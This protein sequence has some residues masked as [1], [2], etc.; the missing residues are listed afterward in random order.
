MPERSS[1]RKARR[2]SLTSSLGEREVLSLRTE[3][4]LCISD[5]DFFEISEK[6]ENSIGRRIKDTETGQ[7]EIL[8][9]IG[10]PVLEDRFSVRTNVKYRRLE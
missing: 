8:K 6:V 10:K 1:K 3:N 5:R 2:D 4:I 9:I 7:R